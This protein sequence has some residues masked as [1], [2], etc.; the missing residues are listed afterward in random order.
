MPAALLNDVGVS[1]SCM[2]PSLHTANYFAIGKVCSDGN[3]RTFG[4]RHVCRMSDLWQNHI[5]YW[6]KRAKMSQDELAAAIDPPTTKGTIS[7][8]ESGKRTPSQQRL[9]DIA[10]ALGCTPGELLDGPQTE[11]PTAPDGAEEVADIPILGE[12]P[13]GSWREAVR[14][15]RGWTHIAARDKRE[16]M[17]ALYVSGDSMDK[18]AGDGTLIIIDPNDKDTFH[19]RLFVVRGPDGDV[20]FK[21]YLDGPGRLE[22]CSRNPE[23]QTIPITDRDYE[24]IGRVKKIILDPDQA[25]M[26]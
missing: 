21:R 22:P 13:A 7:Q 23:H 17:Y 10:D 3:A 9:S 24:I 6:R 26:D 19:R 5:A 20:T 18:I 16:G 4:L 2:S 12:V 14:D 8:Y 15:Y 25:A 1:A 11:R